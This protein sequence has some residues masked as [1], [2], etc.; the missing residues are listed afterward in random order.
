MTYSTSSLGS[1]TPPKPPLG[2]PPPHA[3]LRIRSAPSSSASSP[4][5]PSSTATTTNNNQKEEEERLF[6]RLKQASPRPHTATCTTTPNQRERRLVQQA[7]SRVAIQVKE[8]EEDQLARSF[9]DVSHS[10]PMMQKT[11]VYVHLQQFSII[12]PHLFNCAPPFSGPNLHVR[13]I[14][15]LTLYIAFLIIAVDNSHV[16]CLVYLD[17]SQASI[18]ADGL[19]SIFHRRPLSLANDLL[20]AAETGDLVRATIIA[21]DPDFNP[22]LCQGLDAFT[23]LHHGRYYLS[24]R[25]Q[26]LPFP[27]NPSH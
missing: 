4:C 21:K 18:K 16:G 7:S 6:D 19:L 3:R 24:P 25:L 9:L 2:S 26:H 11:P 15:L 22:N 8:T 5:L 10:M 13:W 17:Y 1:S 12:L 20:L 27:S 23:P 14:S